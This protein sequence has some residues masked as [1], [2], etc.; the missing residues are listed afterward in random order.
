MSVRTAL[1]LHPKV[2]ERLGQAIPSRV[3]CAGGLDLAD[4][5]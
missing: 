2:L 3:S 1:Y 5:Q 4:P